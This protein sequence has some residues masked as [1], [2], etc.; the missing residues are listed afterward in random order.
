MKKSASSKRSKPPKAKVRDLSPRPTSDP[1]GG[2]L[3]DLGQKLQFQLQEANN[4]YQR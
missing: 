1:K 4:I 3:S 2:A